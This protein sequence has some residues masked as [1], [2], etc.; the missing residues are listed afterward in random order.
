MQIKKS[1]WGGL[2]N[3]KR[4]E[5][6]EE[7]KKKWLQNLTLAESIRMTEEILSSN[8]FEKFRENFTYDRPVNFKLGLKTRKE[9]VRKR[10]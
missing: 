8:M 6:M 4:F 5:W 3:K 10:I 7:E 2:F 1:R 9:N